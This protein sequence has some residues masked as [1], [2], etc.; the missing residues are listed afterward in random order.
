MTGETQSRRRYSKD[1]DTDIAS[2]EVEAVASEPERVPVET[3]VPTR[4]WKVVLSELMANGTVRRLPNGTIAF[5]A[6]RWYCEVQRNRHDP[7]V[8][9]IDELYRLL[10]N[11]S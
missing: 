3:E 5:T 4:D 2:V 6:N 7:F 8:R 9:A 10:E 11:E 1:A